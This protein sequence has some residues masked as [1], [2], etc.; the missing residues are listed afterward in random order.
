MIY[1]WL[2]YYIQWGQKLKKYYKK[3]LLQLQ[4]YAIAKFLLC[5]DA[6]GGL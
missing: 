6:D 1:A 3:P 2:C 5:Q 4:F